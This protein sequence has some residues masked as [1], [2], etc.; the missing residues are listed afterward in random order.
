MKFSYH[1][2]PS[3]PG[4]AH[5][6]RTTVLRPRI[7]VRLFHKNRFIDLLALVDSG[8]DDCLF[9][10]EVAT[11]LNLPL[12]P[13]NSNLY[14]GIGAGHISAVFTHVGLGV[15]GQVIFPLYAGFSDAPSVVPILG[16]AGFFDRF[17]VKF[18]KPKEVIDLK[19][20]D[21]DPGS[22]LHEYD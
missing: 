17:E 6:D 2:E 22:F 5:Q 21:P 11:E 18:N 14:G 9:P 8:A 13:K 12:N 15:A 16:Q 10:L 19:F 1:P 20:V 7:R 3:I 4:K